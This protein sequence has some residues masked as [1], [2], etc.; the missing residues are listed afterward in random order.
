MGKMCVDKGTG[1]RLCLVAVSIFQIACYSALQSKNT[2]L[3]K[4]LH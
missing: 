2:Y 4:N 1:P 3:E